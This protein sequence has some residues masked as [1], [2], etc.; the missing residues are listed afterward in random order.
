M[1][2]PIHSLSQA[3]QAATEALGSI[4]TPCDAERCL[5][6]ALVALEDQIL[7]SVAITPSDAMAQLR[8]VASILEGPEPELSDAIKSAMAALLH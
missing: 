1:H 7:A 3:I 4:S 5:C 8:A 6:D 2:T